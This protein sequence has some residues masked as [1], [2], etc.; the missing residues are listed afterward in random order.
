[1]A[2]SGT[3]FC[4]GFHLILIQ[5][6]SRYGVGEN[7]FGAG[8]FFLLALINHIIKLPNS[9]LIGILVFIFTC[10]VLAM[11]ACFLKDL[12]EKLALI[13]FEISEI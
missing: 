3:F 5:G 12:G 8:N 4:N 9:G 10:I 7:E 2:Y 1:M 6:C 11:I 13:G